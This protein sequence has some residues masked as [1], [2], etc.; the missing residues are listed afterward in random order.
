MPTQNAYRSLGC[1]FS[2]FR[3]VTA[4]RLLCSDIVRKLFDS[5]CIQSYSQTGEDR[6][7]DFYLG[8]T[9]STYYVDIG[10]HQPFALSN[11][12]R[13]Y[14]RGWHGLCIDGNEK[15]ISRFQKARPRDTCIHACVSN[16]E[17]QA[18][19][20]ISS[21]A[22][23]STLS[24][25]FEKERLG[26]DIGRRRV[27]VQTRTAQSLFETY[28]VPHEFA[29]LSI[30]VEGHDFE[31]LTSFDLNSY[32]PHL[33]IIELHDFSIAPG[34]MRANRVCDYLAEHGY[35][36]MAYATM[37]GYFVRRR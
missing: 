29:L 31:V 27:T 32:K 26:S 18:E 34:K 15:L 30:D 6:L 10:C 19:F 11:T 35:E 3:F 5:N 36:L 21:V 23:M 8:E 9:N 24:D 37:N 14:R 7:I 12:M 17:Q 1:L 4:V 28:G 20:V 2:Q 16:R 25:E 13:L 22:A 33:I